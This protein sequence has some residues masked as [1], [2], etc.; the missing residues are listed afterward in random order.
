MNFDDRRALA[1]LKALG[2]FS[3]LTQVILFTHHRHLVD[4]ARS[5]LPN[6]VLF[7]RELPAT[8]RDADA[9]IGPEWLEY[10]PDPSTI[11]GYP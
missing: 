1:A 6:D 8:R 11:A 4:L 9:K 2:E 10:G 3:R 7:V 5:V